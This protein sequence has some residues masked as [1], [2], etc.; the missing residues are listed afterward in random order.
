MIKKDELL[1]L[2]SLGCTAIL[3]FTWAFTEIRWLSI[4]GIIMG[5]I[6]FI[7]STIKYFKE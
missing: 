2:I 5:I 4:A 7:I 1:F 6:T 3:L